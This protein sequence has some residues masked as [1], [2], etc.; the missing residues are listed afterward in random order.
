ML[1]LSVVR[2][3]PGFTSL[4]AFLTCL[5]NIVLYFMVQAPC[6][7]VKKGAIQIN[8]MISISIITVSISTTTATATVSATSITKNN[9]CA[10]VSLSSLTLCPQVCLDGKVTTEKE[11]DTVEVLKAIQKAKEVK[12]RMSSG[13]KKVRCVTLNQPPEGSTRPALISFCGRNLFFICIS[14]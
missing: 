2:H 11:L 12:D 8:M 9:V 4:I 3:C 7:L 6:S 13:D 1:V 5:Y 14:V 10:C